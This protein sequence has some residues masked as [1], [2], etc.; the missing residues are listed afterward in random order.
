MMLSFKDALHTVITPCQ[1]VI[2]IS[3]HSSE[4]LGKIAYS[5]IAPLALQVVY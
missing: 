4:K 3:R 1:I 2:F 5:S